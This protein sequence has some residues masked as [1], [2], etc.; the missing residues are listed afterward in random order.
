MA[1]DVLN[2][3]MGNSTKDSLKMMFFMERANLFFKIKLHILMVIGFIM[4]EME[5]DMNIVEMKIKNGNIRDSFQ[6]VKG[7][8]KESLLFMKNM[9]LRVNS[10]MIFPKMSP[11]YTNKKNSRIINMKAI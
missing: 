2:I 7:K 1:W 3:Q 6:K 8:V 4:N 10:K 9:K 5:L 11:F